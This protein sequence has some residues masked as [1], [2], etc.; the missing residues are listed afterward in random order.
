MRDFTDVRQIFHA[1]WIF[2]FAQ[3]SGNGIVETFRVQAI[4]LGGVHAKRAIHKDGHFG[5]LAVA[6]ELMERVND[7]L[8]A[9]H[10]KRGDDDL[11]LFVDRL[12][13]EPADLLIGAVLG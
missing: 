1:K 7:L 8:R 2:F 4:D 6:G 10:G 5:Q 9:A 11:S 13:H 3:K 12:A